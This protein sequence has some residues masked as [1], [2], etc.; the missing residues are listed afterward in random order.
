[1]CEPQRGEITILFCKDGE[2]ID[3]HGEF[4]VDEGQGSPKEDEVCI[5]VYGFG[6]PR[7]L[8]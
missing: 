8:R 5:A 3:H 7:N 4:F 1:M 2:A 6:N